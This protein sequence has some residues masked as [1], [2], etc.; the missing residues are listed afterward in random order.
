MP[1]TPVHTNDRAVLG[2]NDVGDAGKIARVNAETKAA[3]MEE[4]TDDQLKGGVVVSHSRHDL[5]SMALG[6]VIGHESFP[7]V[8]CEPGEKTSALAKRSSPLVLVAVTVALKLW[9]GGRAV[10]PIRARDRWPMAVS[11]GQ[12]CLMY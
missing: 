10:R 2:E 9:L 11:W 3:A 7:I 1:K 12:V 6:K 4:G 8:A 5:R